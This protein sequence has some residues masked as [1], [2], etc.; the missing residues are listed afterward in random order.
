MCVFHYHLPTRCLIHDY[1]EHPLRNKDE[2]MA[3][4]EHIFKTASTVGGYTE[5][6]K[7][8]V[9]TGI[10]DTFQDTFIECIKIFA[11]GLRGSPE[12]KQHAIDI[13]IANEL[14]K[15][16]M[17]PVWRIEGLV[18][19]NISRSHSLILFDWQRKSQTLTRI[20]TPQWKF[21]T[22]CCWGSLSISGGM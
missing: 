5:A 3:H 13:M 14:P 2:M 4:L 16:T 6:K 20:K 17:S 8:K 10:K 18:L 11:K 7:I 22:L 9:A 15:S 21:S 19:Q 12:E 1:Q